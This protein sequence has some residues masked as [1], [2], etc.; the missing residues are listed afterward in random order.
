MFSISYAMVL[1]T[2]AA[3][4]N[5]K[6]TFVLRVRDFTL[7]KFYTLTHAH[8]FITIEYLRLKWNRAFIVRQSYLCDQLNLITHK[9]FSSALM[10]INSF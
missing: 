6:I 2:G 9:S 4:R 1:T 5:F 3:K 7:C 10:Q 8:F